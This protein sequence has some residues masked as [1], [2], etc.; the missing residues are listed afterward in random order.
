MQYK[1]KVIC[2]F[3]QIQGVLKREHEI[4]MARLAS[5][6]KDRALV[7]LRR[8]KYQETLLVKTDGQLE[9]LEQLVC[10]ILFSSYH[11]QLIEY[12]SLPAGVFRGI[13]TR[14]GLGFSWP[15]AGKRGLEGDTQRNEYREC[16][17]ADG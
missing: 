16:G 7:A 17:E 1:Q 14:A 8:K 12:S 3:R 6:D 5:G 10:S 9:Q 2:R 11:R 13:L 15:E 4:A